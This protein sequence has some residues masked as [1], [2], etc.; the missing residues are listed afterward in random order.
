MSF[1]SLPI[2]P[3]YITICTR[4]TEGPLTGSPSLGLG[5]QSVD[6]T[7]VKQMTSCPETVFAWLMAPTYDAYDAAKRITDAGFNTKLTLIAPRLPSKKIVLNDLRASF[8]DVRC[9]I[10]F[11][12][13]AE[14]RAARLARQRSAPALMP[15]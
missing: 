2:K 11:E 6:L 14:E 3:D 13:E 15:A 9:D 7:R 8:P 1:I 5:L 10:W 4:S 12:D